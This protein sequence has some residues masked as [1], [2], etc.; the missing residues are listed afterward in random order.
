VARTNT[1]QPVYQRIAGDLRAL[2][3]S[4]EL[5]PDAQV[6]TEHEL[7]GRY[8][9]ARATVRQGLMLLV[10]EGLIV[11][12]RPLGYFVRK[13]DRLD[14]S[15]FDFE[16]DGI[17]DAW[18]EAIR[19]GGR[20]P[21]QQIRVEIIE[22]DEM[23]ASRLKLPPGELAVARRRL[24]LVDDVPYLIADS[25]YP[26]A[27]VRGTAIVHPADIMQGA[28][29]VLV[30]LGYE[31]TTH[32]DEIEGRNPTEE[33]SRIL[34][35]PAGL[36]VMVHTRTSSDRAGVPTRLMVSV[37]PVDRWRLIYRIEG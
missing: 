27:I 22:P 21:S 31:W 24:R 32:D 12:R 19:T 23:I 25:F 6:P 9:V 29:H 30:D 35:I 4:G 11:A 33:E 16:R 13:V 28:R 3:T 1:W 7:A 18:M 26:E 15:V 8:G 34:N 2:I 5:G 14:W 17:A 20:T 37:L 36:S 10:Q